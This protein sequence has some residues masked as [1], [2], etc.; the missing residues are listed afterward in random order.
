MVVRLVYIQVDVVRFHVG[1]LWKK[2]KKKQILDKW[3]KSGL[4]DGLK[5]MSGET[6]N[7]MDELHCCKTGYLLDEG[8]PLAK[9]VI[10]QMM[11]NEKNHSKPEDL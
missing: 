3:L 10:N 8:F 2:N 6:L 11:V 9:K 1:A 5:S 4:L 7:K